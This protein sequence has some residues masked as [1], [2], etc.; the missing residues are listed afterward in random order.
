[1][2]T[3]AS[4]KEQSFEKSLTRLEKVVK[5]MEK[6][7]LSLDKMITH[8]EEGQQLVEFCSK[9]LNE[10]ERKIEKLVQRGDTITTEPLEEKTKTPEASEEL[11]F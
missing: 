8:F 3:K 11:P 7:D 10:V 2:T 5:D 9:K 1:M 6:G 4:D